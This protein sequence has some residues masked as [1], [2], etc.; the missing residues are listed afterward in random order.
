[1]AIISRSVFVTFQTVYSCEKFHF[2]E[3]HISKCYYSQ[4]QFGEMF[5]ILFSVK[6][7]D[8]IEVKLGHNSS[9]VLIDGG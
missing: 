6:L 2:V 3:I 5:I 1:M 9:P 8:G 7:A 4:S